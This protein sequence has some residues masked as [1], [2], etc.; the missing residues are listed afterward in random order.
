MHRNAIFLSAGRTGTFL[1]LTALS[2]R[3]DLRVYDQVLGTD[4]LPGA[5][6]EQVLRHVFD[7]AADHELVTILPVAWFNA[8]DI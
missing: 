3:E 8:R 7:R 5:T 4:Y 6:G 2:S 1:V